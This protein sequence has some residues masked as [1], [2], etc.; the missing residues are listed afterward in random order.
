M[1]SL[2]IRLL[3]AGILF[4]SLVNSVPAQTPADKAADML[5]NSARL[6]YNQKNYPFAADRFREFLSKYGQHKEIPSA[7]YGL[8]LCLVEGPAKD[9][10]AAV[11]Q[12]QQ[13][14]TNKE[15]AEYPYVLYYLALSQRGLGVREQAAAVAKPSEAPRT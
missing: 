9:Y 10:T 15:F 14:A 4:L 1:P 6:A 11:E 7:R 2:P 8:A 13:L 5:L 12:L 3:A